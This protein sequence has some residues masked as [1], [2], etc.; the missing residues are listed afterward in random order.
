MTKN[1]AFEKLVGLNVIAKETGEVTLTSKDIYDLLGYFAPKS[2]RVKTELD[3]LNTLSKKDKMQPW[4][5]HIVAQGNDIRI[6]DRVMLLS[7]TN[8]YG[9]F[10]EN[11]A[12]EIDISSKN[13]L[14]YADV[15]DNINFP[16]MELILNGYISEKATSNFIEGEKEVYE[17]TWCVPIIIG[18][19]TEYVNLKYWNIVKDLNPSFHF[20]GNGNMLIGTCDFGMFAFM[21]LLKE[22]I[23]K[24]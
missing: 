8:V 21:P 13:A 23:G 9:D 16:R 7:T 19:E 10:E 20:T 3:W 15:K 2:R 4:V 5:G 11:K 14:K 22:K 6:A 1:Q 24:E 17:K 12:L 18:N